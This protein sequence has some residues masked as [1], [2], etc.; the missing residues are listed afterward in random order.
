MQTIKGYLKNELFISSLVLLVLINLAGLF[1]FLFQF[2]MAQKLSSAD[3]GIL[4]FLIGLIYIFNVP[5]VAIQSIISK[6][7]SLLSTKKNYGKIR[8][9][10]TYATKKLFFFSLVL[11]L[12]Y[13]ALS[14][15]VSGRTNIP[16]GILAFTGL[17]II[18]SLIYPIILGV[19]QGMKKFNALGWNNVINFSV[20]FFIGIGLVLVGLRVYGV[21][22]GVIAGMLIAWLIAIFSIRKF[23]E[24]KNRVDFFSK[25]TIITFLGI[26]LVT[27]FYS[28]DV[29]IAKFLFNPTLAGDYS[30]ASLVGKIIL[31]A[32]ISVSTVMFPLS[33]EKHLLKSRTSGLLKKSLLLVSIICLGGIALVFLLPNYLVSLLF[34]E[35]IPSVAQILLPLSIA[36]AVYSLLNLLVLYRIS[37]NGFSKRNLIT[38]LFS[39]VIQSIIMILF[40]NSLIEFSNAFMVSAIISLL[41]FLIFNK[42]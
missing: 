34:G 40:S 24:K 39:L 5:S 32:C 14:L 16:F 35:L 2:I 23:K 7:T 15:W 9:L 28:L 37:V 13:L 30:K 3:F 25:E 33:S 17:V 1:N 38:L 19:M 10:F 41:G 27:I 22:I 4:A 21:I 6:R 8:G 11:L 29:I 26:L 18:L 36:F 20:K 31:F 12:I 42:K